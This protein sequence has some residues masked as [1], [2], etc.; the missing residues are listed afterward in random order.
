MQNTQKKHLFYLKRKKIIMEELL[1]SNQ[2]RLPNEDLRGCIDG[3]VQGR[4]RYLT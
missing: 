2:V 1:L 3:L 4:S